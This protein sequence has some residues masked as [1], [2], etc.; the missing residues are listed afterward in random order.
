MVKGGAASATVEVGGEG[1]GEGL[2]GEGLGTAVK[3]WLAASESGHCGVT[4]SESGCPRVAASGTGSFQLSPSESSTWPLA[5]KRCQTYCEQCRRCHFI[6]ISLRLGD[7]SWYSKCPAMHAAD[8][9]AFRSG[10]RIV[11]SGAWSDERILHSKGALQAYAHHHP[12][13]PLTRHIQLALGVLSAPME[14]RVRTYVRRTLL[15]AAP[16]AFAYRFVIGEN[17]WVDRAQEHLRAEQRS[18]GDL[19]IYPIT[20]GVSKRL[21]LEKVLAWFLRAASLFPSA[22]FIGKSDTDTFVSVPTALAYGQLA[23]RR[24]G[25][26][27]ALQLGNH[28]WVSYDRRI[29]DVC[30]CCGKS[31]RV[32]IEA[33]DDRRPSPYRCTD[34]SVTNRSSNM[35]EGPFPFGIGAFYM[36]SGSLVRW[37]TTSGAAAWAVEALQT[38]RIGSNARYAED[39]FMGYLFSNYSGARAVVNIG[40]HGRAVHTGTESLSQLVDS[41]CIAAL[42]PAAAIDLGG[43]AR[44]FRTLSSLNATKAAEGFQIG[45]ASAAVHPVSSEAQWRQLQLRASRW[46]SWLDQRGG[47]DCLFRTNEMLQHQG[48]YHALL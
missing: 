43:T 47:A 44:R 23:R 38:G 42:G 1:G 2:G 25:E 15:G 48:A 26:R 40:L 9:L 35:L 34:A 37:L 18:H 21:L 4:A 19:E 10:R 6:S 12:T 24:F 31:R 3:R 30:G 39:Q 27:T 32:A 7:C 33:R 28:R 29:R 13:G 46:T 20:D 14:S 36:A 11:L 41:N 8:N 16:S 17:F 45:P 22:H 5:V